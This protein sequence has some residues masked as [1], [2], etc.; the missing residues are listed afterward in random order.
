MADVLVYLGDASASGADEV[1]IAM[2]KAAA[3][4]EQFGLSFEWLGAY[5]A[6]VSEET[7]QAPEVIGTALNSIMARMHQIKQRGFNDEDETSINDVAKALGTIDV[8]LVD[9]EGNWRDMSDIINDVAAVWDTLSDKQQGYITTVMAGTRQQN[10]FL[11]L[12]NDLSSGI[13][14]GSR[15]WELYA[16]AVSSAGAA[17]KKY[18]IWQD[19]VAA[20]QGDLKAA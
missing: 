18:E 20:A 8:A 14:N 16:G 11:T 4:A 9:Q 5:I 10:I 17:S 1:G 13:E 2:Q 7:R 19:S 12:M 3:S 6:T 15:A